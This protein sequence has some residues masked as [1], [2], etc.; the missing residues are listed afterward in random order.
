MCTWGLTQARH[1]LT[2]VKGLYG[3]KQ[4]V[5]IWHERPKASMEHLGSCSVLGT[6]RCSALALGG[7]EDWAVC[8]FWFDDETEVG[9]RGQ[10]DR[11]AAMSG[12]N[13]GIYGEG[14]LRGTLG[15]GVYRD[16]RTHTISISQEA[17]IDNL[18]E[19][20]GLQYANTVTTPLVDPTKDQFPKTTEE[21]QDISG[22]KYRELLGSLQYIA[23]AARPDISF[24]LRRLAQ[25]LENPGHTHLEA[26]RCILRYLQ[27]TKNWT[28]NLGGDLTGVEIAMTEKSIGAYV[29]RIGDGAISWK[30]KKQTSVAL[31]SVEAE[32]MAMCQAAKEAVWLTGLLKDF[33]TELRTPLIAFGDSEDTLSLAHNPA[34]HPRSKHIAIQYHFTRRAV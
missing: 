30:T 23:L 1:R 26:A 24:A 3:L 13:Y 7:S 19:R 22:N 14:E 9:S 16:Y 2:P 4:A 11:V 28:L 10:L 20:F 33:S 17:Y 15:I 5:R 27:G 8:A 29:F 25:F 12:Q 34:F 21:F 18:V 31:S 6:M 32:Y